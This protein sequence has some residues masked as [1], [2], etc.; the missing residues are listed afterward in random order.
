MYNVATAERESEV[1]KLEDQ[2]S[3]A[4]DGRSYPLVI[5]ALPVSQPFSFRPR[6]C[7]SVQR[8][9]RRRVDDSHSSRRPGPAAAW[10]APSTYTRAES[11]PGERTRAHEHELQRMDIVTHRLHHLRVHCNTN[12]RDGTPYVMFWEWKEDIMK[13]PTQETP[14]GCIDYAIDIQSR[15]IALTEHAQTHG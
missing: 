13:R 6:Q 11:R 8:R 3:G 5:F 1:P 9:I 7:R 10:M 2:A 14:V 4:Y 15:D 12:R